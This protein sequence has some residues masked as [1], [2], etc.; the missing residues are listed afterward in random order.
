MFVTASAA[1]TD[2]N[3]QDT[4][5]AVWTWGDGATTA[6]VVSEQGGA[7]TVSGQHAYATPGMYTLKVQVT[8]NRGG[9]GEAT[10]QFIIVFDPAGG[11]VTGGGWIVSPAG[12]CRLT[13]ACQAATGKANFNFTA[14][15]LPGAS[16]PTGQAQF[17][18][19][20]G[21]LD[22]RATGFAW[23]VVNGRAAQFLGEGTLNGRG[24][25]GFLFSVVDG[26]PGGRHREDLIRI[27]IWDKDATDRVVYDSQ[28]PAAGDAEPALAIGG[29]S[30]VVHGK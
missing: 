28:I 11:F 10:Y 23:L 5:T 22:F 18:F 6:G 29:G 9:A 12:A 8:D 20:A 24:R 26:Q 19:K 27:K 17:D 30:I 7:G 25:Y 4:H 15:Y 13:P 14:K 16:A 1:F 21:G 3:P 2:Q